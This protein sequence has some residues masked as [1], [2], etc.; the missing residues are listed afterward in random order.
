MVLMLLWRRVVVVIAAT[1]TTASAFA[2][3]GQTSV[4]KTTTR[5]IL[6]AFA[7]SESSAISSS[8]LDN[9]SDVGY[10]VTVSRPLGI[11]FG[12]NRAP[13]GG[14]V[15][16]DVEP[17]LNG[18]MAG[19]RVGD[20]LMAVNNVY[21]VGGDFDSVMN[22]L[23]GSGSGK[24]K[25]SLDLQLYRGSVASLYTIVTNKNGGVVGMEEDNNNEEDEEMEEI[26]MDENYEPPI[27]TAEDYG[28]Q[29]ISVSKVAGE[30]IKSLGGLFAGGLKSLVTA[31]KPTETIQLEGDDAKTGQKGL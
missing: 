21:V 9:L 6:P 8:P 2:S 27:V 28:D 7:V 30:A 24:Q 12:E 4:P 18:G 31:S 20:Q 29:T 5:K 22:L 11:V 15:V 23:R 19:L 17:G 14:L 26:I 1:V 13:F 25:S 16:D 10:Q 3:V